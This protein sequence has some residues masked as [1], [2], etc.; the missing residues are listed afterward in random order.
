MRLTENRIA[1]ELIEPSNTSASGIVLTVEGDDPSEG[2]VKGVGPGKRT[3]DGIILPMSVKVGD[4]V[5]FKP[6]SGL[7]VKIATETLHIF[8][9]DEIFAVIEE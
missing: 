3:E 4:R 1:V 6:G 9:E 2:I 7:L 5:M 8:K